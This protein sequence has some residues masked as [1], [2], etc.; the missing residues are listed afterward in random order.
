MGWDASIKRGKRI[1]WLDRQTVGWFGPTG[2]FRTYKA[3]NSQRLSKFITDLLREASTAF[4]LNQHSADTT[5]EADENILPYALLCRE[6]EEWKQSAPTSNT[7]QQAN[8]IV[9]AVVQ[10][11]LMEPRNPLGETNAP[12]RSQVRAENPVVLRNSHVTNPS[13]MLREGSSIVG[14]VEDAGVQS[15]V[16]RLVSNGVGAAVAGISGRR[17][18]RDVLSHIERS[19]DRQATRLVESLG[20]IL[21][22]IVHPPRTILDISRDYREAQRSLS[23]ATND[24]SET[25]W[26][27]VC[28]KLSTELD[29]L[30]IN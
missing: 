3:V 10:Q 13:S 21:N 6:F 20:Q 16:A 17:T 26:R 14:I 1:Q 30:V 23:D 29:N 7:Q 27:S 12:L 22:N 28:T 9:N 24:E 15:N 25:F 5:G 2:M 8:R 19:R 18:R 11:S 4:P